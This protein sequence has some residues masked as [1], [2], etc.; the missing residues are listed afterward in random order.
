VWS[1]GD[2]RFPVMVTI[3]LSFTEADCGGNTTAIRLAFLSTP[4]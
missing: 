3:H 1:V 4:L 2:T